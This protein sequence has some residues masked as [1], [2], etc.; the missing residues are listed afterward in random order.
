MNVLYSVDYVWFC[1]VSLVGYDTEV[2]ISKE[3]LFNGSIIVEDKFKSMID[4]NMLL[5]ST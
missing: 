2:L 5:L 4:A 3:S 1:G